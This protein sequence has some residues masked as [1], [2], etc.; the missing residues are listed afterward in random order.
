M[1]SLIE[2]EAKFLS[3][4]VLQV[5]DRKLTA[6]RFIIATGSSPA[7]P[8][9]DGIRSVPLMTSTDAMDQEQ[10]PSTLTII[11]GRA[12]GLEFAQLY[13][14]LGTR[15]TLIQRSPRIIPEEDPEIAGLM[16]GY[17]T[18]EG[19]NIITGAEIRRIER[20]GSAI[21][22]IVHVGAEQR[23]IS[24]EHLFLATGRS[25]NTKRTRPGSAGVDTRKDG[26]VIVD[27]T[28]KTSAPHI[29]AAGDVTG[30]PM[31]ETAAK[32]GGEI[33]ASNALRELK[34]SYNSALLPKGIF[35]M[36]QVASVGMTEESARRA[37]MQPV[38]HS[39]STDSMAKFSIDGDTRG[40]VKI[41]ADRATRRILGVHICAPLATEMIQEG[42]IAVMRYLTVDDLAGTPHIFP[43]ATEALA[44]C[45]RGL[46]D[47]TG[48]YPE[49]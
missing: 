8:P 14:H 47:H 34:R 22:V 26:A 1:A 3:P 42:V 44:V 33:A 4:S 25:P 15:V 48:S 46:R 41:V 11:G 45:A 19:I 37:G 29:W 30:E 13:A 38:S 40:L 6:Q 36:P 10:I 39:I 9:L 21:S 24:G 2:G 16:T 27:T 35:T 23:V 28:L 32:Y 17:L 7:V 49:C 12:L 43:T 31:L 18:R 20:A 5:G